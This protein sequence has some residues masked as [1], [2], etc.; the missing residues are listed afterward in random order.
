MHV[1]F[2]LVYIVLLTGADFTASVP[3][4]TGKRGKA[5]TRGALLL[6]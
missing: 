5:S 3:S 4:A 2:L 1:H 6:V